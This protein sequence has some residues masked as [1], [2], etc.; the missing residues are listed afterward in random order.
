M[1]QVE[2]AYISMQAGVEEE[3]IPTRAKNG[4]VLLCILL[5]FI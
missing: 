5:T 3:P 1:W 4:F 2:F